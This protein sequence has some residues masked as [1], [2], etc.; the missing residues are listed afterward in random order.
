MNMRIKFLIV[1]VVLFCSFAMHAQQTQ[2]YNEMETLWATAKGLYDKGMYV[3]AQKLFT[4]V[5]L[6]EGQ[7]YSAYKDDAAYYVA[8]CAMNLFN[9]DAEYQITSFIEDHPESHNSNDAAFQMANFNFRNKKYKDAIEWYEKT[10]RLSLSADEQSEYFFKSGFSHFARKDFDRAAKAFYESKDAQTIYGPM[11]LYFYSH[12]KYVSQQYQTALLGFQE[13]E[14]N[15][16]FGSIAPFYITQIYYLQEKYDDVIAYAPKI[17][18]TITGARAAETNKLLGSSY[19]RKGKYAEAIPYLNNYVKNTSNVSD[20]DYYELGFAYYNTGNYESAASSFSKIANMKDT[21]SQN[22]AYHMG[23]CYLK[24]NKKVEARQSFDI[25]S[26]YKFNPAI[27]EDAL[28]N[29]AQLCFELSLSPFNE[30]INAFS[31]YIKEYPNSPRQDEAYDFLIDAFLSTKNYQGAIQTI[32][33]MPKRTP[34]IDA[35]YQRLTYFRGLEYF[36]QLKY[37][38]A[39]TM[40]DKSLDYK[41]YDKTIQSLAYYWKAES[42]YRMDKTDNAITMFQEFVNSTGSVSLDEYG[43]AHYNLGYAYFNKKE[44]ATA[45]SWFRKFEMQPGYEKSE[46]L[47]DALNRI[48]DCY[49]ISKEYGP[50]ADYYKKA[51]L[52]GKISS[53]YTLYQLAL[54]YGGLKQADQKVWS[55]RRLLNQYPE[56]EYVSNANFEIGRTYHTSLNNPDSAKFYYNRLITNYPSSSMKKASL[57][58]IAAIYF[59]EKNY[60]KAEQLYK[61]VIAEFPNTEEASNAGEMIK[62][63]YIEQG[64]SAAWIEYAT[65]NGVTVTEDEQDDVLWGVAKK[66]YVDKKYNEAL[67]SLTDYLTRFPKGKYYIEANYFKAELHFY[68]EEKDAALVCY[69]AVAD[70]SRGSYTEESTLKAASILFDKKQWQ[71]A[72]NY[73][74]ILYPISENKSTKLIAAIGKLRCAYSLNN[75]DNVISSAALVIENEKS[76]EEQ[77]REAHYKM[78][79]SYLAKDN[80]VRALGLF[81][82]LAKEVKSVEGAESRFRVAEIN[83]KMKN[84]TVAENLIYEFAQS[85]SPHGYWLAKSF[86]LLS[87]IYYERGDFFSAKH[88]LQSLLNNYVIETDGIKDEASEKLTKIIDEEQAN[89]AQEDMLNL[90]INLLDEGGEDD[91]LFEEENHIDLPKPA[92]MEEKKV[93]DSGN[94][95]TKPINE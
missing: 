94:G 24:M 87:D 28:Y 62:T 45:N 80:T 75:Y 15:S 10:D 74:D 71:D 63:I 6:H 55:L 86:I 40:F 53:D 83:Y 91:N 56:S 85:N 29:Y 13:L 61:Q 18:D 8:L 34:K 38:E 14:K 73:Y 58:S 41:I 1:S 16:A 76:N 81:E 47:N 9:K 33:K 35:A 69:R 79:K 3:P 90:K 37:N 27:R 84:D 12:I 72:Y 43:M 54:S 44:Y 57:S 22:A 60:P 51:A 46:T 82:N 92:N 67:T 50:A 95:E 42:N 49:F 2:K 48:G 39:I 31:L 4:Q 65:E 52:I 77:I 36:T 70:A 19:Y 17:M 32:E 30:A 26:Q 21:L 25:A 88:T 66:Q 78:A 11:S 64:N 93:D 68:F 59:N 89:A 7:E 20:Y 5:L 23:D